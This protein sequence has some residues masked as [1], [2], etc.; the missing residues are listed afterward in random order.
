MKFLKRILLLGL[1]LATTFTTACF[2]N[3]TPINSN[4]FAGSYWLKS[5][6][7][8][9]IENVSETCVYDIDFKPDVS[10]EEKNF[11]TYEKTG[12]NTLTTVLTKSVYEGT[13]C[14]KFTTKS[15]TNGTYY[16]GEQKQIVNDLATSEVYF[17]GLNGKLAPLYSKK[18]VL[19]T[20]PLIS[21]LTDSN[22]FEIMEY[23]LE[24]KYDVKNSSVT[25]TVKGGDKST[26]NY[27]VNDSVKVYDDYDKSGAF[28]DNE[29][30][31]FIPRAADLSENG[32][33][34][35]FYTIDA[36]AKKVQK[37]HLSVTATSATGEVILPKYTQAG[38]TTEKKLPAF[39]V[40]LS[41]SSTF[42]G[43]TIKLYY[44]TDSNANWYRRLLKIEKEIAFGAGTMVY[45]LTSA[46]YN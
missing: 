44:A 3:N 43:S 28:F 19:S 38:V 34:G 45:T 7:A 32:F 6:D 39:N 31:M 2:G 9:G 8:G 33:S 36:L 15:V 40:S 30:L 24:S 18:Y 41:I 23:S 25:V 5:I 10:E 17:L 12:E 13:P 27:K 29:S 11:L 1:A 37:M 26:Q 42:S 22:K 16:Y 20:I 4:L 21:P 14:Y 46:D 35:F